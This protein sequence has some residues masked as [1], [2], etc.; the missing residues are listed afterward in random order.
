MIAK[1]YL[2]IGFLM[3]ATLTCYSQILLDSNQVRV[4]NKVFLKLD[5]ME[6]KDSNNTALIG[7]KDRKIEILQYQFDLR[8]EQLISANT[9]IAEQSK[10]IKRQKVQIIAYQVII[11]AS[12]LFLLF[13][14]L[15]DILLNL[16]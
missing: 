2:L 10:V 12:L 11:A 1:K 14:E 16:I 7:T 15:L 3:I 8:S 5:Y 4:L 9:Q 13:N 6:S